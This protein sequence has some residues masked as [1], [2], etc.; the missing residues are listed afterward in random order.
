MKSDSKTTPAGESVEFAPLGV[1]RG[2]AAP[3]IDLAR[4][5]L[6]LW[7]PMAIG[8]A[9][10]SVLGVL[11]Y[12]YLGPVYEANTQIKVS[13]KASLPM[14]EGEAR[15][16]GD[17]GEHVYLIKSDAICRRAM[18][19]F[20]LKDLPEFKGGYDPVKDLV[21]G[22]TVKRTAGQDTS[23]DNLIDVTF[24]HPDKEI[25]TKVVDAVVKAYDAYLK[26]TRESNSQELYTTLTTQHKDVERQILELEKDYHTWRNGTVFL[27]TPVIVSPTGTP[28]M[29]QSPYIIELEKINAALRE[30]MLKRAAVEAK[31]KT[32]TDLIARNESREAVQVW[33]LWSLSTGNAG[34]T[35]E[36]G[37]GGGAGGGAILAA[38]PGKAELDTQLLSAR[39]LEHRLL[40]Q[41]G[42]NHNDVVNVHRSVEAI[43][44]M[45][46]QN[47]FAP[48]ILDKF[49]DDGTAIQNSQKVDLASIYG[50]VLDD[51]LN[52]LKSNATMLQT[53]QEQATQRAKDGLN[54][55]K[56]DQDWKERIADK[57]KFRDDLQL[58]LG[59]YAQTRDQEGYRLEQISQIRVQKS[60]KRVLKIVGPFAFLGVL[61]VFGLAYFREW[62]D[63]TLRTIESLRAAVG[64]QLLGTVPGFRP[65]PE[66]ERMARHSRLHPQ[67]C[68]AHHPG[69]REAESYRTIRTAL[70]FAAQEQN[71]RVIQV[72]SSEPGDGKTTS[73]CNLALAM[74]QSGKRVLLIDADLRRPTV[75]EM[76]RLPQEVGLSDALLG[77]IEWINAVKKTPIA[78]LSVLTAGLAPENPSELLSTPALELV[79]RRARE[80]FDYVLVDSPPVLAVSDPCI[81]ATHTDGMLLVVRMR[82]NSRAAVRR[83]GETLDSYGVRVFGV[84]ANDFDASAEQD[85]YNYDSY[86]AYYNSHAEPMQATETAAMIS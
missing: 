58:K 33:V 29:G 24:A 31:R 1:N 77:E 84:V 8:L 65:T 38:P 52:E 75:H 41:L 37:G 69:S 66:V 72:S 15:R 50:K 57:K 48:P 16:Y 5:A 13:K 14:N 49:E 36:T 76:F 71:A 3:T 81:V 25:A 39:L 59:S 21:D 18:V 73:I 54:L 9:A 32:L 2:V 53:L 7:K 85:G 17:R 78:T 80:E 74:A 61:F 62:Y 51:Q 34:A 44:Q 46:R 56:K 42:P 22:L 68:Y 63:T 45:Y 20:G 43:L 28:M 60:L 47:G 10:G 11:A 82:K 79:L 64:A 19:D 35:G 26:S 4:F 40:H 23:F 30:N 55:E 12:M 86:E 27:P 6:S 67:L 83:T 70:L